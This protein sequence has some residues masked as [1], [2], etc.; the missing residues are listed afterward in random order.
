MVRVVKEAFIRDN[1]SI[2][3]L[4]IVGIL[5]AV[6]LSI[7]VC[8]GTYQLVGEIE[9][10][11]HKESLSCLEQSKANDC[12]PFAPTKECLEIIR[13]ATKEKETIWE[14]LLVIITTG[15]NELQKQSMVP[16]SLLG[17]VVLFEIRNRMRD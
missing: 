8:V 7:A 9:M 13:C 2:G 11:K 12:N 14:S 3:L 4:D 16:A 17:L 5:L 15:L 6:M 1:H 10:V